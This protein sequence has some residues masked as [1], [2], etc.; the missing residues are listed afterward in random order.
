M[1]FARGRESYFQEAGFL[2]DGWRTSVGTGN[3]YVLVHAEFAE[4][5]LGDLENNKYITVY[6]IKSEEF[7]QLIQDE[8]TEKPVTL[9][10]DL[11]EA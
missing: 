2:T 10:E 5:L 11:P 6:D 4:T 3:K 7:Q 8:F 1:K 9:P